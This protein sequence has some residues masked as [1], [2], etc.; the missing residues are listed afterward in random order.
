MI[1]LLSDVHCRYD[2]INQQIAYAS[3]RIGCPID[4]VVLLGDLGLFEP[5]LKN[6]FRKRRQ[7]LKAPTY[8]IEGNHEDFDNFEALVQEYKDVL[9]Y[10]PRTTT[11]TIGGLRFLCLGGAAYMDAHTTPLR[12]EITSGDIERC[13]KHPADAVDVIISHDCP[14]NIGMINRPGFEHYGTPGFSG[15]ERL[16]DH[17][18]AKFWIFGHHHRWYDVSMNGTRYCGLPH[19]WNGFLLLSADGALQIVHNRVDSEEVASLLSRLSRS[20]GGLWMKA[21][22]K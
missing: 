1:L 22:S 13:L 6:Y 16:A 14:P 12:A 15:G 5:F 20:I 3:T 4:A 21:S 11:H 9:T 18:H 17:F 10:L 8:F 7:R 19:S 2:V